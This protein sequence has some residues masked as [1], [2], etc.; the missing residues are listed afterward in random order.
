MKSCHV[1]TTNACKHVPVHYWCQLLCNQS[2]TL[3]C[4]GFRLLPLL[5]SYYSIINRRFKKDFA[6]I[7]LRRRRKPFF[8]RKKRRGEIIFAEIHTSLQF[9]LFPPQMHLSAVLNIIGANCCATKSV[10]LDAQ[11]DALPLHGLL[12]FSINNICP[13]SVTT[14]PPLSLA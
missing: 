11:R 8:Y 13:N 5:A 4:I 9:I 2:V 3:E 6:G 7:E 14:L 12:S 1:S 10:T